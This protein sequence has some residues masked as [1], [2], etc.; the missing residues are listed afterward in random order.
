MNVPSRSLQTCV[1]AVLQEFRSALLTGDR[2][3]QVEQLE[4]LKIY[5]S[6]LEHLGEKPACDWIVETL[7]A[8][9]REDAELMAVRNTP[10]PR[11]LAQA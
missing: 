3:S 2:P 4:Q 10:S 1:E 7:E 5:A 6:V 9:I 8:L 11:Q